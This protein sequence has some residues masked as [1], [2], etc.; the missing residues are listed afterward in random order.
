MFTDYTLYS[1]SIPVVIFAVVEILILLLFQ[2]YIGG[3]V[4][5]QWPFLALWRVLFCIHN[6]V[7]RGVLQA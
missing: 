4:V 3:S 1:H 2:Q 7:Y 5:K 6:V